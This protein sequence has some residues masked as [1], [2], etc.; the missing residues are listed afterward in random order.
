MSPCAPSANYCTFGP[1]SSVGFL[2]VDIIFLVDWIE[3]FELLCFIV[4]LKSAPIK[5]WVR[6]LFPP[7]CIVPEGWRAASIPFTPFFPTE[8]LTFFLTATIS[9]INYLSPYLDWDR[10]RHLRNSLAA[11]LKGS[12]PCRC[13]SR[14]FQDF[15]RCYNE[16][17]SAAAIDSWMANGW[18][19]WLEELF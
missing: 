16:T 18:Y 8:L 7:R 12:H 5:P 1:P 13:P 19:L 4:I 14:S 15:R 11:Y 17:Y 9:H 3:L 2:I 6:L 10:F